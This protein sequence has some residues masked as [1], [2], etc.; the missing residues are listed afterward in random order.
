MHMEGCKG[1]VRTLLPEI[2]PNRQNTA[3]DD[4][5]KGNYLVRSILLNS[6]KLLIYKKITKSYSAL[7]TLLCFRLLILA[8]KM[9]GYMQNQQ[10]HHPWQINL[11]SAIYKHR[12]L[13]DN[14]FIRTQ[15]HQG[16]NELHDSRKRDGPAGERKPGP[17][18]MAKYRY[19]AMCAGNASAQSA[20]CQQRDV[21]D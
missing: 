2:L 10:P 13:S 21:Q 6:V 17:Y 16:N 8:H 3:Y 20:R 12:P 18:G 14:H 5:L 7:L 15:Q 11:I 19:A 9:C 4:D 1:C